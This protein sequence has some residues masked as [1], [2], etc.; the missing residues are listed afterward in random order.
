[1]CAR[2]HGVVVQVQVRAVHRD[3]LLLG[4]RSPAQARGFGVVV[5]A[6]Y[7]VFRAVQLPED[8]LHALFIALESVIPEV[9]DR[10]IGPDHRIPIGDRARVHLFDGVERAATVFDGIGVTEMRVSDEPDFAHE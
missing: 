4:D 2:G 3:A 1:L 5:V 7:Q 10:V 6:H 8:R 9:P